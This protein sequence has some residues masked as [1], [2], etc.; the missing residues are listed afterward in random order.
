M[1]ALIAA[2]RKVDWLCF[3]FEDPIEC[4]VRSVVKQSACSGPRQP[5]LPARYDG[6]I[7]SDVV[8]GHLVAA[9]LKDRRILNEST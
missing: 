6:T 5:G 4:S 9:R 8:V 2:S 3:L 7:V 1:S